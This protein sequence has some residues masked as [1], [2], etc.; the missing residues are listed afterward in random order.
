[1]KFVEKIARASVL[2]YKNI[3][4]EPSSQTYVSVIVKKG[5]VFLT[6]LYHHLEEVAPEYLVNQFCG[7][8]L[9]NNID[10][11]GYIEGNFINNRTY[12]FEY[13]LKSKIE[14]FGSIYYATLLRFTNL[15]KAIVIESLKCDDIFFI[16]MFYAEDCLDWYSS[17]TDYPYNMEQ[18]EAYFDDLNEDDEKRMQHITKE[19]E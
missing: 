6:S 7:S 18:F 16:E 15:C 8:L 13:I 2:G 1:M 4:L 10:C 9:V 5:K 3:D 19:L 11:P 14:D 12:D 17:A